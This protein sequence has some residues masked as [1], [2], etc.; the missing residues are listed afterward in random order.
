MYFVRRRRRASA[1]RGVLSMVCECAECGAVRVTFVNGV[2]CAVVEISC[3]RLREWK[4][5][6]KIG[7]K[8]WKDY[9]LH[10][11]RRRE[12]VRKAHAEREIVARQGVFHD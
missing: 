3:V 12:S 10:A 5:K 6:R 4:E 2:R 1:S 11:T 9:C 8:R 7:R